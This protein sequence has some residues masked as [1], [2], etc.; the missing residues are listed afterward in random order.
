MTK[1]NISNVK[2]V[3]IATVEQREHQGNT[4]EKPQLSTIRNRLHKIIWFDS[5][6]NQDVKTKIEKKLLK[7]LKQ[8]YPKHLKLIR[9]Q[10]NTDQLSYCYMNSIIKQHNVKIL[11]AEC[12]EK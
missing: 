4:M 5:L 7:L 10:K 8:H 3:L 12:N 2:R 6:F 11:S 9:I 1:V